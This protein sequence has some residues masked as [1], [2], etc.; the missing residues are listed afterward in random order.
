MG[1]IAALLIAAGHLSPN[2][3]NEPDGIPL[4]VVLSCQAA[5]A[6]GTLLG[7]W[8][9]VRTMGTKLTRLQPM[10]GV[11]SESAA[12][13]TLFFASF[14]GI[15]VST[16]HTITGGIVGVGSSQRLSAVRWN[17]ARRVA[18][19]WVLTIPGSAIVAALTYRILAALS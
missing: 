15:P 4:W 12:A 13:A 14:Q 2:A 6:L 16:T 1:I 18:W 7:G 3:L 17:I 11:C 10:G 19:A 5:I 9:I 8:R